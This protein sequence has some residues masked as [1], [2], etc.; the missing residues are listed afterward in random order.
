M[1]VNNDGHALDSAGNVAVD[2]VWGP[3]PLQPNDV[4]RASVSN[5][6][7]GDNDHQWATTTQ[8]ASDNLAFSAIPVTVANS[9]TLTVPADNHAVAETGYS[10]FPAFTAGKA[11]YIV[12]AV[13]GDG[14]VATYTSQNKFLPGDSVTVTGMPVS[15]FNGAQTVVTANATTFTTSNATTGL[16]TGLIYGKVEYTGAQAATDG[17]YVSGVAYVKVP[18]VVGFTEASATDALLDAELVKGTVITTTV[19]YVSSPSNAGL[20]KTQ[21]VAAGASSIAVGTAVNLV[22]FSAS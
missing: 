9:L 4:R 3:F 14:S 20:V 19:G 16:Y 1:A 12:T 10:S 7:G 8:V 2:F 21:S 15:G 5:T 11:N 22:L 6:G 13:S 18:S 17:A